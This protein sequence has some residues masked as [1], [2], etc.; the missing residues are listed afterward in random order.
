MPKDS[1]VVKARLLVNTAPT[2][3]IPASLLHDVGYSLLFCGVHAGAGGWLAGWLAGW[4]CTW[5]ADCM[6]S[7]CIAGLCGTIGF[8]FAYFVVQL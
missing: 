5:I 7:G 4:L 8:G 1:F 6:S 3:C 2:N